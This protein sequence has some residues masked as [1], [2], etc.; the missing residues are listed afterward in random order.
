MKKLKIIVAVVLLAIA[1]YLIYNK[2]TEEKKQVSK[3]EPV[4]I[5]VILPLT[6]ELASYGDPII[7]GIKLAI[8]T[9]KGRE[10]KLY[11]SDSKGEPKTAVNAV[12]KMINVDKIRYFIGDVSSPVTLSIV[13]L[14]DK[15]KSLIICPGASS[16]KLEN[17]SKQ[18]IRNYPSSTNESKESAD[19]I[20]DS[21]KYKTAGI[22][23]VNNDYGIGMRETF[24][25]RFT[26][27]G[28]KI[29]FVDNYN[30]GERDFKNLIVKL[31]ESNVPV[32]Y[33]GGNPKE[34]GHFVKQLKEYQYNPIIVSNISFLSQDCLGIAGPAAEGVIIP[35]AYYNPD[36]TT[37]LGVKRFSE[38]YQKV[39]NKKP[40]VLNAIGYDAANLIIMGM[41]KMGDDPV[42][43]AAY[44]RDLKNYDG[45]LGKLSFD[46]GEV[47]I[48]IQFKYIKDGKPVVLTSIKEYLS[49]YGH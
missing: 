8:E 48:P 43:I 35:V 14:I 5:G 46:H 7:E 28:G 29:G 15:S 37:S 40:S 41:D 3:T 1:G 47:S 38:L 49:E 11:I 42:K 18:F 45:A 4:K 24:E 21:L 25:K 6:G 26:K 9:H 2:L 10:Y 30:F 34:M 13:P 32:I 27:K 12:N 16:P 17:I 39:K 31:K 22:V 33:L 19:F 23:Y 20:I 44:L 36:D